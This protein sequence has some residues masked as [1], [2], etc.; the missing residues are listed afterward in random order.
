VAGDRLSHLVQLP[1]GGRRLG[2]DEHDQK[3]LAAQAG[4]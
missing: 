1:R 4:G 2:A 3:S